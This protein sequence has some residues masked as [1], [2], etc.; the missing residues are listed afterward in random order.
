MIREL[1]EYLEK[2]NLSKYECRGRFEG[3]RKLSD[4]IEYSTPFRP[5]IPF[6]SVHGFQMIPAT[7]FGQ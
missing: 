3:A 6:D 1:T 5:S 2:I 4:A 7:N